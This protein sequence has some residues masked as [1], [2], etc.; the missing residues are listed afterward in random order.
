MTDSDLLMVENLTYL[1]GAVNEAP[2]RRYYQQEWFYWF[3]FCSSKRKLNL[4]N[5]R[6]IMHNNAYGK[7]DVIQL[8]D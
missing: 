7:A 5:Q 3:H 8:S 1:N 4:I 6:K 2:D